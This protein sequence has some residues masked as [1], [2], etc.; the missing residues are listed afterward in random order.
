MKRL[1][2]MRHA[3]TENWYPGADDESRALIARGW[4][5]ARLVAQDLVARGS[6]PDRVIMST[7]R[8]T[9]ETWKALS[10]V[11]PGAKHEVLE[12]LYAIQANALL[13]LIAA[14]WPATGSLLVIGHN[15][16][17]HELACTL[18][19]N[20][21]RSDADAT[22]VLGLK[23]PTSALA[24][25]EFEGAGTPLEHALRLSDFIVAKNLRPGNDEVTL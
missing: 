12:E 20:H 5:D 10:D 11:M 8:R 22:R 16:G 15:P 25:F 9:R 14:K 23:M 1:L 13:E 4:S 19:L 24:V 18:A 6:V 21:S 2:L 3:K 7:A 17:I